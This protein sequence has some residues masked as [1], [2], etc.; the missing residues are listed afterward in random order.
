MM[1]WSAVC[2]HPGLRNLPFKI[3]LNERGQVVMSPAK[4][5]HSVLQGE[6][7][8]LLKPLLPE[9]KVLTECAI[10]TTQGTKVADVAW[11]SRAVFRRVKRE[12]ECSV[13]P[14]IC[15]E[16]L[17]TANTSREMEEKKALYFENGAREVWFCDEN[18]E[19]RFFATGGELSASLLCPAFPRHL[20]WEE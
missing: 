14:E 4:V 6:I 9:G 8:A 7:A 17:S 10:H 12:A 20:D 5:Y 2:E 18:G 19:V 1:D 3:E 16:I 15:I 13:A 11:I